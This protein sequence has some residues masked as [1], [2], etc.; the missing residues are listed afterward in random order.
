MFFPYE[1]VEQV[2]DFRTAVL[3]SLQVGEDLFE[4]PLVV[5]PIVASCLDGGADG[6]MY[7]AVR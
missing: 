1:L 4:D 3:R 5:L 7:F 6:S 2:K